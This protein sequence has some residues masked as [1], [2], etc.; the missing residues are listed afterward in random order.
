M[1]PTTAEWPREQDAQPFTGPGWGEPASD[2]EMSA[3]RKV[4]SYLASVKDDVRY[5]RGT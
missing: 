1:K 2:A 3:Y 5:L 4:L